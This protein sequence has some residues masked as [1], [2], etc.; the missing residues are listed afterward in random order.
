MVSKAKEDLIEPVDLVDAQ[1]SIEL[2]MSN[3]ETSGDPKTFV[4]AGNVYKAVYDDQVKKRMLNSADKKLLYT[5]LG[6]AANSAVNGVELSQI[7]DAKG[8]VND[9]YN[10]DF[11]KQFGKLSPLLA[12]ESVNAFNEQN[13]KESLFLCE[14]YMGITNCSI[15][16]EEPVDTLYNHIEFLAI[17]S[18][19]LS[20]NRKKAIQYMTEL[21]DASFEE[22]T[23]YEWLVD[24]YQA[25]KD[26]AKSIEILTEGLK[27]QPKD[28]YMIGKLVNYYIDHGKKVEAMKY[29]DNAIAAN[30]NS[31]EYYN[32]KA[33]LALADKKYSEAMGLYQ[34]ANQID[35]KNIDAIEGQGVSYAV[36]GYDKDAKADKQKSDALYKKGRLE[37]EK[38]Y[39]NA[40]SFLWK[41]H[42]MYTTPNKDNLYWLKVVSTRLKRN[43]KIKQIDAERKNIK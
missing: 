2:A 39:N 25:E 42:D 21:K 10:K 35:P 27:K 13:Y 28:Q 33:N 6:N 17:K 7:P 14:N 34:K 32:V 1:K 4:V 9:K 8:E 11:K 24:A 43:D 16:K 37:A 19:L 26:T 15:M 41:A 3:E 29:L 38:D 40:E 20:N 36:M 23:V 18:A 22:A 12:Q 5:S 30:P 31:P